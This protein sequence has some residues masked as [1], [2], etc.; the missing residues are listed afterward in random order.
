MGT[1]PALEP[2]RVS[3]HISFLSI[4]SSKNNE[5]TH[6][7]PWT[8]TFP[9]AMHTANENTWTR[10]HA[11][12]NRVEIIIKRVFNQSACAVAMITLL[13][14]V[15][16]ATNASAQVDFIKS[17]EELNLAKD[18]PF[19]DPDIIYLEADELDNDQINGIL[20]ASGQVEGRYQD[21]SLRADKVVYSTKTGRVVATGNVALINAD[22]STQYA[23]K[24]E[25]S[26][27]LEA[28]TAANFTARFPTGGQLA[29]AL[30]VRD[31][32]EGVELYNAY[33]TA[34]EACKVDGKS[35]KPTWRLK[36]RKVKQNPKNKS[37][38]Y[39]DAV[40]EFKGI[41][42]LYTPYLAHPDPTAGRQSGWMIPFAGHS[43]SKGFNFQ[44]PYYFALS[45][46]SELTL[47]PH[48]YQSVNPLLE[49]QFRKKFHTGEVNLAG[50]VTY[51][52]FFDNNGDDF[53]DTAVFTNPEESLRSKKLRSHLFANGA[54][55]LG[56]NWNWGF[57]AGYATDDNYLDRYDLEENQPKFG[58]Y[59]AA[60]RRLMQQI[61]AVGQGDDFRLST[62]AFGFVSLRTSVRE[63]RV[64]DPANPGQFINDRSV[65]SVSRENDSS[66]PVIAPKIELTK[67]FTDPVVG[68]RL[69]L[70][71][72]TTYLTRQ[73]GQILGGG[74]SATQYIRGTGGLNWQK[75]WI[76]P[77]GIEV[78]PFAQGKFD[79][80]KLEADGAESFD[81][82]RTTGQV[83]VDIRWPFLNA[84]NN[85]NWIIEPRVQLTQNF[86][87]GKLDNFLT[88]NGAGQEAQLAQDG[89]DV[90]LDQALLWSPNK[91]T[92][93]D[94]WQEGFRADV[95][96][97]ISADW[98]SASGASLFLGQS[99]Y[100][101]SEN[102]AF[103][104]NS[105]LQE[106]KSDL[107]GSFELKLGSKFSTTTRVR[108]DE[109]DNKFRRLDTGFTYRDKRFDT[110]WRYYKVDSA[111]AQPPIDPN[112][113]IAIDFRVPT[114]E[115]S[116][117]VGVKL[118]DNW[119]T[120]YTL[121]RDIDAD[122][123]RRQ[124]LSLIYDDACTR[125]ELYYE[126][127]NNGLGIVGQRDGIGIRVSLLSLGDFADR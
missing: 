41:P 113:P 125:I 62:S 85:I 53:L 45:P 14:G 12:T 57:Q 3:E 121:S 38:S 69:K 65:I 68:G 119:S 91:S 44:A 40:F 64:A 43:G 80:F 48:V 2:F 15:M 29:G 83:G 105:G 96:A 86:G 72:D 24:L 39:R 37:I 67:Y 117:S 100:S 118:I 18:S 75:N 73:T 35:K 127:R 110:R 28:G 108:Y 49:A 31:S 90:D 76:A 66:L 4:F 32:E 79:F 70:F 123:T 97:A 101:G 9:H 74:N 47:T 7:N 59:T 84:G 61:F 99:Y 16:P 58:L 126:K 111:V 94:I 1:L 102:L 42:I 21:K 17:D 114:Q 71:G 30:A 92:G 23:D 5:K 10:F 19:R 13:S 112:N 55:K 87:D 81:F 106:D 36:A 27:E 60:S 104:L 56:N 33:Y 52:N 51:S 124:A 88:L 8:I 116:G 120:R 46:Y 78:K 95:G 54:F 98:G 115:V 89:L 34:C 6:Q 63:R 107:V 109:D 20:T 103:E 93:F 22:G 82:S 50:S 77:A 11:S 25:L 122:T 26:D